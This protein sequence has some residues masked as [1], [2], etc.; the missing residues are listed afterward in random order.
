MVQ[1]PTKNL[2]RRL[3]EVNSPPQVPSITW[4]STWDERTTQLAYE[5]AREMQRTSEAWIDALDTKVVAVFGVSSGVIGLVTS[6]AGLPPGTWGRGL[7]VGGLAAWVVSALYCWKAFKPNDF[8]LDPDARVLLDE[9]W[10]SLK[11]PQFLLDRLNN[12][13]ASVGHNQAALKEK[14]E[15]LRLALGWAVAEVGLL[16]GALLLK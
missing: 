7:W 11:P 1:E 10:L 14:A 4:N 2:E 5:H 3:P 16:V 12:V 15:A 9:K 8:R 13:G 6:L